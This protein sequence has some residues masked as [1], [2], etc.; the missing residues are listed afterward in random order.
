MLVS[1]PGRWVVHVTRRERQEM[2]AV[3]HAL[4]KVGTEP[5]SITRGES[6]ALPSDA[7]EVLAREV[8]SGIESLR[9]SALSLLEDPVRCVEGKGGYGLT[10]TEAEGEGLLQALNG[11]RV[12]FWEALGR[13][14]FEA[15]ERVDATDRN[16]M[17]VTLM[18]VA[19]G[20]VSRWLA[21]LEGDP[22]PSE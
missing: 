8:V 21:C 15:G 19:G 6:T 7:A 4:E 13:P 20:H 3:L 2:R 12:A 18:E 1:D 10:V 11:A 17:L 22:G 16:R 5:P 14:D 9:A